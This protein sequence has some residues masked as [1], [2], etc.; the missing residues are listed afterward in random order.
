MYF[1]HVSCGPSQFKDRQLSVC[2][3]QTHS[4]ISATLKP[5]L[6]TE[7]TLKMKHTEQQLFFFFKRYFCVSSV[8]LSASLQSEK[9]TSNIYMYSFCRCFYPKSEEQHS[10]FGTV[11]DLGV[12]RDYQI[13]SIRKGTKGWVDETSSDSWWYLGALSTIGDPHMRAVWTALCVGVV[14]Q[15]TYD[16]AQIDG[17]RPRS[18]SH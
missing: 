17:C 7:L 15:T 10:S 11:G 1:H 3:S 18:H 14:K 4:S 6:R 5:C 13:Y 8:H 9:Q 2:I 16:W 12:S